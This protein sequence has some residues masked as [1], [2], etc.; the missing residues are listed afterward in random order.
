MEGQP[1]FTNQ[2]EQLP[3]FISGSEGALTSSD[4]VPAASTASRASRAMSVITE[5]FLL[6]LTLDWTSLYK[7]HGRTN[8]T[9]SRMF[10]MQDWRNW[11][12]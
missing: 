1:T 5:F 2:I 9:G 12:T 11:K 6:S 7:Y 3:G 10:V 8:Q 4:L